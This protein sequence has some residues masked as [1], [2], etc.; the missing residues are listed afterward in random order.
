MSF[1][2]RQTTPDNAGRARMRFNAT[3]LSV[4]PQPLVNVNG[5]QYRVCTIEYVLPS[6]EIKKP[7]A[8]MFEKNFMH[9]VTPKEEYLCTFTKMEDGRGI[10]NV[11][12]LPASGGDVDVQDFELGAEVGVMSQEPAFNAK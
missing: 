7:T 5:T 3:L 11:S 9:G 2:L 12:H 1:N 8:F 4:S 10:I 6:G